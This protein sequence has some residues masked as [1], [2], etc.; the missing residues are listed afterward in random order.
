MR[1]AGLIS[2]FRFFAFR[3]MRGMR[4]PYEAPDTSF[5]FGG[6]KTPFS[7]CVAYSCNGFFLNASGILGECETYRSARS[8]ASIIARGKKYWDM[9][10]PCAKLAL[11]RDYARYKKASPLAGKTLCKLPMHAV[12]RA[13]AEKYANNFAVFGGGVVG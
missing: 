6:G 1:S 4:P 10:I 13:V 11:A 2:A 9:Q 5:F 12:E 8:G 3:P 7:Y